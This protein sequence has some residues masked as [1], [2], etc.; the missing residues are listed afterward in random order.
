MPDA[1]NFDSGVVREVF[2]PLENL[3]GGPDCG[4]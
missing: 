3:G 4:F 2:D 1:E